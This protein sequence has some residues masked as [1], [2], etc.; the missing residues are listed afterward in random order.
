MN[1]A[2]DSTVPVKSANI[3]AESMIMICSAGIYYDGVSRQGGELDQ[4]KEEGGGKINAIQMSSLS[5]KLS[6]GSCNRS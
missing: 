3:S 5:S 4:G 1:A 2:T 6:T